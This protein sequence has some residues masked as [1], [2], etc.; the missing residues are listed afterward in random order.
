LAELD[1]SA[2]AGKGFDNHRYTAVEKA[3]FL[4][5]MIRDGSETMLSREQRFTLARWALKR[6]MVF[7]FTNAAKP[8]YTSDD[9]NALRNGLLIGATVIWIAR[10]EGARFMSTA[11]AKA[12]KYDLAIEGDVSASP[13][14]RFH[15]FRGAVRHAGSDHPDPS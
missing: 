4:T 2:L 5:P 6:A 8:F 1:S 13:G 9:R 7:E 15:A 10:Y 11:V 14:H 12:L 3:D